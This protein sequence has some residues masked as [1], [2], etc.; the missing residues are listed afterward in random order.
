MP[1]DLAKRQKKHHI[2][3]RGCTKYNLAIMKD[4][5]NVPPIS[6]IFCAS[7]RI[8]FILISLVSRDGNYKFFVIDLN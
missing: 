4:A 2:E 1:I 3:R 7:Q 6:D 5:T 8:N